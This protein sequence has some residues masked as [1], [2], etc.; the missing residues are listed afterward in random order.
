MLLKHIWG[1]T[2]QLKKEIMKNDNNRWFK[3]Y[4]R[5]LEEVD[6]GIM[7]CKGLSRFVD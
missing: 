7:R 3:T 2:V 1:N 6:N 5:Y 4:G